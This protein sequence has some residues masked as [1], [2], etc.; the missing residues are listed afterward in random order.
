MFKYANNKQQLQKEQELIKVFDEAVSQ[1]EKILFKDSCKDEYSLSGMIW[2]VKSHNTLV[3]ITKVKGVY[4]RH[5]DIIKQPD[6][7][8]VCYLIYINFDNDKENE[9]VYYIAYIG[10]K[11]LY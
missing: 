6:K 11:L 8:Y 1:I 4:P 3:D 5:Y 2:K 10:D 7:T 9:P